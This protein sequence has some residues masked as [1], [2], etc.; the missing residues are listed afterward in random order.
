MKHRIGLGAIAIGT[1]VAV[2]LLQLPAAELQPAIAASG[3]EAYTSA[4]CNMCHSVSAAGIAATAKMESMLGPDLGGVINDGNSEEMSKYIRK[5]ISRNDKE[6]KKEFK[7]SAEELQP[8]LDWLKT[9]AK[10]E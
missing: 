8:I 3:Q 10:A 6:H 9:Q 1:L 5:Q 2:G 7:G 4:K